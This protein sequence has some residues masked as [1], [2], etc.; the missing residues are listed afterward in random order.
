MSQQ[1]DDR[2]NPAQLML[3]VSRTPGDGCGAPVTQKSLADPGK[4]IPNA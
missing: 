2:F 4:V 3:L 1:A